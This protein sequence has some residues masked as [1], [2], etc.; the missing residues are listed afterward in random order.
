MLGRGTKTRTALQLAQ[1]PESV[2]AEVDTSSS[3]E[4][5][6]FSGKSL[7]K[8]FSLT[9]DLLADELRNANFPADQFEKARA[10][11]SPGSLRARNR[12]S[13][14]PR[15]C[16]TTPIF[17]AGHPYHRL[18][19]EQATESLKGITRDDLVAF[20]S[21]YYRSD[22]AIIVIAGDVDP[23]QAVELVK[24][25]FGDWQA[26]GPKPI[27]DIPTVEPPKQGAKVVIPMMDKT[28]VDVYFGYPMGMKRSNPDYYAMRIANQILGGSGALVS[29]LGED[30]RE[31]S[32]YVYDVY[33]TLR[34]RPW[35]GTVVCRAWLEPGECGQGHRPAAQGRRASSPGTAR[36]RSSSSA[37][38]SS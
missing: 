32:G 37:R 10:R 34:R 12:R 13:R 21:E 28:E 36:P 22:T 35:R 19:V 23:K 26:E 33:S 17:P 18:T 11:C 3:V 1:E 25:Y 29:M 6:S 20:H 9:L 8:D 24:K 5:A 14:R 38:G 7:T 31:K 27:V 15:G 2:G 30:I 16:S 4:Y